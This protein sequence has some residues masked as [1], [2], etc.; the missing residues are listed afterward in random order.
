MNKEQEK[1][2][3]NAVKYKMSAVVGLPGTGKTQT[4][5]YIIDEAWRKDAIVGDLIYV[6]SPTGKCA[7]VLMDRLVKDNVNIMTIAMFLSTF[8]KQKLVYY[9]IIID[10][11][12]MVDVNVFFA[13]GL[14]VRA[15]LR[16]M[17]LVGDPMQL[18]PV[19]HVGKNEL[20]LFQSIIMDRKVPIVELC[21]SYRFATDALMQTIHSY[22]SSELEDN[23]ALS[24]QHRPFD[25]NESI[26]QIFDALK[27]NVQF[28]AY[29]NA[30][31]NTYNDLLKTRATYQ[32]V[33][34]TRNI[35]DNN[36]LIVCNGQIG[37]IHK[38]GFLFNERWF[39]AL[40]DVEPAYVITVHAAQGSQ[41][42]NVVFLSETGLVDE[43][44]LYTAISRA[45][46]KILILT[47]NNPLQRIAS[48]QLP[49]PQ[50]K[51]VFS[52]FLN[53]GG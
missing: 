38:T 34:C 6:L 11:M 19:S 45:K 36:K 3:Y 51:S 21:A 30:E 41:F 14:K 13:L 24:I 12:S 18:P 49:L 20:T 25:F 53:N 48:S 44:I 15:Q 5:G 26:Q 2:V 52:S 10:E 17:V 7:T 37:R 32:P 4:I 50:R 22:F 43:T 23:A 42:T 8:K 35:Y 31:R 39:A 1:A 16:N 47:R 28:I 46:E 29:T 27:E 40:E 33:I 9:R